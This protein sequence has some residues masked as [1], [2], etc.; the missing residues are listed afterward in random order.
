ME[1]HIDESV[2]NCLV[3]LN[4]ALCSFERGT[5]RKYTLLLIPNSKEE[6][7]HVSIDG[8]PL[9]R[10]K[11]SD[12]PQFSGLTVL[13]ILKIATKKRENPVS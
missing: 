11:W 1:F 2:N 5:G 4:D 8:K 12:M 13:D 10:D 6:E 9:S 3:K 7:I